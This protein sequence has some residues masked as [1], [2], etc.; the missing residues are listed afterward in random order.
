MALAGLCLA[1]S[2]A[3]AADGALRVSGQGTVQDGR[4]FVVNA[5][6]YAD[7]TASGHATLA[8]HAFSGDK[9]TGPYTASVD[10]SRAKRAGNINIH[11]FSLARVDLTAG[12]RPYPVTRSTSPCF[13][14]QWRNWS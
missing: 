6:I 12:S 10:I 7:G 14:M 8:N 5:T 2:P 3:F 4:I 11:Q 9:G 1:V 13:F